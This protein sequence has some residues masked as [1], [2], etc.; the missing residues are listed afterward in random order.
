MAILTI[1]HFPDQ[2]LRRRA[3]PVEQ[4]DATTQTLI[5]DMLSTMYQAEGIGLAATQVNVLQRI[6][7][8]DVSAE[9]NEPLVLINPEILEQQGE[10]EMSEGCL[11]VPEIRETVKRA[12]IIRFRA[13][14]Q[15]GEPFEM[16]AEGLLA[17]CVQHEIDHLDGK[18]FIDYLSGLKRQ[19]IRKK[20]QKN[21]RISR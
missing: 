5:A 19:R 15:A 17:A 16:Q 7:T 9:G 2:R 8:I 14:N 20:V 18:L 10:A 1:L 13:L 4:V 21:H 12:A 11:S 3:Q 6:V